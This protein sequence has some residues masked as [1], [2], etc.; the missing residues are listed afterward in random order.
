M[1]T[2]LVRRVAAIMLSA[3]FISAVFAFGKVDLIGHT[4]IVVVLFAIVADNRVQAPELRHQWLIPV[5]Y[6]AAL[7]AFLIGYYEAHALL[8]GTSLT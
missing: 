1:W 3:M 4:L 7:A 5:A 6:V 8:F 2:P